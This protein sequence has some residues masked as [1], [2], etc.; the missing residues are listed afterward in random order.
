[1]NQ[2][3][4]TAIWRSM[5]D[6]D[7]SAKYW[8]YLAHRYMAWERG[9]QIGLA[10]LATGAVFVWFNLEEMEE[11][12]KFLSSASAIV[13]IALP[14]LD[15]RR[16]IDEMS[17]LAGAWDRL[18]MDYEN[19]WIGIGKDPDTPFEET[20]RKLRETATM[21]QEKEV[22]LPHKKALLKTCQSEVKKARG[23]D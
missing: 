17:I 23:L 22:G 6:A 12:W 8:K 18:R 21:L 16:K 2:K 1:M 15:Y 9:L 3:T 14:Y 7:M 19:L 13:A 4:K 5:L 20:Y 10:V 11:L